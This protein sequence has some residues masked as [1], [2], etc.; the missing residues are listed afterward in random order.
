MLVHGHEEE[1]LAEDVDAVRPARDAFVRAPRLVLG[2]GTS[3]VASESF[4][5]KC[6]L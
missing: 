6:A 2:N 5:K 3:A 1:F 4:L